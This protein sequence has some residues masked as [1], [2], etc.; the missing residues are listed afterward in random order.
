MGYPFWL[1]FLL[2]HLRLCISRSHFYHL[3]IGWEGAGAFFSVWGCTM[4]KTTD[5][6]GWVV[7]LGYCRWHAAT[8]DRAGEERRG[9]V[10]R[11][12]VF[13]NIFWGNVLIQLYTVDPAPADVFV[14]HAP[15][16]PS[17]P[18]AVPLFFFRFFFFGLS[19][20]SPLGTGST[21]S[22]TT[23]TFPLLPTSTTA[24]SSPPSLSPPF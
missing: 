8:A 10:S 22:A 4:V 24:F 11:S 9:P 23:S 2:I 7:F 1:F 21:S 14:P 5:E 15:S 18:L 13:P 6:A 12:V 3:P 19:S 20:S 17:A 16:P